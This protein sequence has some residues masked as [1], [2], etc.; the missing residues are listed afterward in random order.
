MFSPDEFETILKLFVEISDRI[1]ENKKK[2]KAKE[3]DN[4]TDLSPSSTILQ[5]GSLFD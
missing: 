1:K 3:R 5:K 2:A 4:N